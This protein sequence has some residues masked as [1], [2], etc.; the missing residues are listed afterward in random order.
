[1]TK[2]N[3]AITTPTHHSN[4]LTNVKASLAPAPQK[5][6]A[7]TPSTH[8]QS[9][10]LVQKTPPPQVPPQ[11]VPPPAS[12]MRSMTKGHGKAVRPAVDQIKWLSGVNVV[13]RREESGDRSE[14]SG[15]RSRSRARSGSLHMASRAR[16]HSTGTEG[17]GRDDENYPATLKEE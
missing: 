15:G 1:M 12:I 10:T 14:G 11:P 9:P 6:A 4:I 7:R 16:M 8:I 17:S 2:K 3:T 5:S 13:H